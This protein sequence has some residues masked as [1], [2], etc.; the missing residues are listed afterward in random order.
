MTDELQKIKQKIQLVDKQSVLLDQIATLQHQ[1]GNK[2]DEMYELT[3]R[4]GA[5][6]KTLQELEV[7]KTL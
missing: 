4:Y 5:I 2:V 6:T 1:I 3:E 7:T